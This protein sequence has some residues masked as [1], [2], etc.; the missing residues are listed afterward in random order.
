MRL[1]VALEL[2]Q[3]VVQ[4]LDRVLLERVGLRAQFLVIGQDVVR[5]VLD[6]ALL[7]PAGGP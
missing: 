2:L 5:H 1:H 3:V 6:A 7:E 4:V